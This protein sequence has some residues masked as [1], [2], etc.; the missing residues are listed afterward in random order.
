M[1]ILDHVASAVETKLE[2]D[3]KKTLQKAI[4]EVHAGFGPL[5]FSIMEDEFYR[6]YAKENRKISLQII[7]SYFWSSKAII[8]LITL[9]LSY[10]LGLLILPLPIQ[11]IQV[12]FYSTSVILGSILFFYFKSM[13]KK[14]RKKSLVIGAQ[15]IRIAGTFYVFIYSFRFFGEALLPLLQSSSLVFAL[16]MSTMVVFS[17]YTK[18]VIDAAYN[19]TNERYLKYA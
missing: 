2:A 5:G 8:T 9:L 15:Q 14:W 4:Q 13:F 11:V 19:W 1:E 3:P 10:I 18:E 7:K 6:S 17:F 12:I 16:I